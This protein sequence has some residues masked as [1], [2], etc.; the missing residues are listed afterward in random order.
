MERNKP[1]KRTF[2]PRGD[3]KREDVS[4]LI[5]G[6]RPITEA[7]RAGKEIEK[8]LFQ[9]GVGSKQMSELNDEIK[10]YKIPFQFVPVEKLNSL[11]KSR[12]HQGVVAQ[13]SPVT[14]RSLEDIIPTVFEKG[15][16]P[17]VIILDRITDVR[18]FGAISRSAECAGVHALIIPSKG[19]AQVNSDAIKTSAG[20]LS[21]KIAPFFLSKF[22]LSLFSTTPPPQSIVAPSILSISPITSFSICLNFS[23]PNLLMKNSS[24]IP[25]FFEISSSVL[26]TCSP[27]AF[28]SS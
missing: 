24:G 6:I 3:E 18:N 28:E 11:I 15:E 9:R 5:F 23:Q 10:K 26:I 17:L 20:A 16:V 1:I 7:I 13:L 4:K 21:Q 8:L 2:T 14:Y 22:I 12:N 27:V 19:S 25:A